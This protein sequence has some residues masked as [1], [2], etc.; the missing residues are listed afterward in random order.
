MQL[1][2][3]ALSDTARLIAKRNVSPVELTRAHLERIAQVDPQ[4]NC[5][6][7]L[8]ADEAMVQARVA[9]VE[10]QRGNYRGALH[11]IPIALKDLYETKDV[12]TTAGSKFFADHVPDADCAVVE[13]LNAAGAIL[14]GKLNMQDRKSTR[15]N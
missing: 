13:K 3:L 1:T 8:T 15:L 6:I 14:L 5:F 7:T 4:L 9:E 2:S 12:R 10:I 11:G